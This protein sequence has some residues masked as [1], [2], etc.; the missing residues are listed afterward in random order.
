MLLQGRQ[1]Q[2]ELQLS[3][4]RDIAVLTWEPMLQALLF[5]PV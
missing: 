5:S 3:L 2:I 1:K 4:G